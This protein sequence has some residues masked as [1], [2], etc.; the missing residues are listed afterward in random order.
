M[1]ITSLPFALFTIITAIAYFVFPKKEY[2][3]VILLIASSLIYVY[4]SFQ[5]TA[6]II[7]SILTIYFAARSIDSI[8]NNTRTFLKSKK[9]EFSTLTSEWQFFCFFIF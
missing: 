7:V 8:T 6:F 1:S 2:R 4:N 3:W 5:Y 9:N